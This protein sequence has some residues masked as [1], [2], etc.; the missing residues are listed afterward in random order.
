MIIDFHTHAFPPAL[1]GRAIASLAHAAGNIFPYCDGT[2]EGLLGRMEQDG[3]DYSVV[4]NIATGPNQQQHIL[5]FAKTMLGTRLIPFASIHPDAPDALDFLDEIAKAGIKG[6]K[7]HPDYQHFFVNE[8][9]MKPFYEKISRLGLITVFHAGDDIG[10]PLPCRCAPDALA[11]ALPWF[12]G[13]PVVAAHFGGYTNWHGV[14]Q[15]LIGKDVYFDTSFCFSTI[16][17]YMARRLVEKQGA[18]R[19]L[20]GTDMPWSP[21]EYELRLI[22]GLELKDGEREQV[23]WGNAKK[24]LGM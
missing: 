9:R 14:E 23:L 22:D 2:K 16:P 15:H 11:E 6:V 5:D 3:V 10:M 24:L 4:L 7:F 13:A 12:H 8:P 20:F 18:G 1:A 21:P 17:I 19:I